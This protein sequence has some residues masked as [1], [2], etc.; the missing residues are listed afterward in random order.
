MKLLVVAAALIALGVTGIHR[1]ASAE[2]EWEPAGFDA[3]ELDSLLKLA[4]SSFNEYETRLNWDVAGKE[5]TR[6]IKSL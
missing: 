2:E 5:I 1:P 4:V 6:L 3:D